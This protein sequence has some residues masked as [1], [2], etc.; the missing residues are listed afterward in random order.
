V[1]VSRLRTD[2]RGSAGEAAHTQPV[3]CRPRSLDRE[4][5]SMPIT[6]TCACWDM[7]VLLVVGAASQLRDW[8]GGNTAG[9]SH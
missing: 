3:A 5:V 9:P 1:H 8:R 4:P 6:G 7:G 2:Q